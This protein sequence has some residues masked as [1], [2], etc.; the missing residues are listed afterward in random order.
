MMIPIRVRNERSL[1]AR[2]EESG[3]PHGFDVGRGEDHRKPG[4]FAG[5]RM[6]DRWSSKEFGGR[7]PGSQGA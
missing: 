4:S 6:R 2:M 7:D 1:W 5:L 3:H